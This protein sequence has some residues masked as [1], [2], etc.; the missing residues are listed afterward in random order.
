MRTLIVWML[1]AL[2]VLPALAD[3]RMPAGPVGISNGFVNGNTY[4][5]WPDIAKQGYVM[6]VVDGIH[7]SPFW[8]AESKDVKPVQ[9]CVVGMRSDQLQAIVDAYLNAQ[10]AIWDETMHTS[11]YGALI[12]ACKV[13][14]KPLR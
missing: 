10:P 8:G 6:G 2:T 5:E 14:G 4:R 7:L 3:A 1:L 12:E 13:R 9:N 11:V